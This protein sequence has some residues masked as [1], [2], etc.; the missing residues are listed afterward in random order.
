MQ[1]LDLSVS[2]EVVD[3]IVELTS[4]KNMKDNPMANYSCVPPEVFDMSI[5]PFM[6]K[7]ALTLLLPW[8]LAALKGVPVLST[9]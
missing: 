6:R 2:D 4:F 5:S 9:W 8:F 1:Y 3:R 7:G